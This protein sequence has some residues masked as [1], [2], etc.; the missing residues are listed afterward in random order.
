[1]GDFTAEFARAVQSA[2]RAVEILT[3]PGP[4]IRP[5]DLPVLEIPMRGWR[6]LPGVLRVIRAS[7]A[8]HVQLEYSNYGWGRWG[9]AFWLNALVVLLRLRGVRVSV[10]LHEFPLYWK[11]HPRLGPLIALQWLH[12]LLLGMGAHAVCTNTRERLRLLRLLLPWAQAKFR[13]RPNGSNI[14]VTTISLTERERMR[15]ARAIQAGDVV[16]CVFGLYHA[17]KDYQAVISAVAQQPAAPAVHLWLLGDATRMSAAYRVKLQTVAQALGP[18]AF[19]GGPMTPQEISAHLQAADIF[20][21]P[22][23]DG[24]LTRSGAFMAAIAH[25][26]PCIAVRNPENQAEFVHGDNVWLV[27]SNQPR[28]I[29]A[30]IAALAGD[31]ARRGQMGMRSRMLYEE[32]FSWPRMAAQILADELCPVVSIPKTTVREIKPTR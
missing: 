27:D 10:G 20:V 9:F 12:F 23:P 17:D 22:Q 16:V 29:A 21:L 14:P 19:W 31:S 8:T 25:G 7:A 26:L 24:H 28:E 4:G 3:T 5:A 6:D 15:S 13:Y 32:Q 18:R 1:M 11:Q 30:A 2:G